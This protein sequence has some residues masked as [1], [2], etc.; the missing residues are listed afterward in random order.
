MKTNKTQT[1]KCKF[2][3]KLYNNYTYI[4][5]QNVFRDS[6]T[7]TSLGTLAMPSMKSGTWLGGHT[8]SAQ[9]CQQELISP[10]VRTLKMV[11]LWQFNI[12]KNMAME[13][14]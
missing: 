1:H 7:Y 4:Y 5:T 6:F 10:T 12:A 9:L 14:S 8:C 2:I 13:N 3:N 11:P